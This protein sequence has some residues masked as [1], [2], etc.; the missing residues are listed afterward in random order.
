[1][2]YMK[3]LFTVLVLFSCG[4]MLRLLDM[5]G[6]LLFLQGSFTG[7]CQRPDSRFEV[8]CFHTIVLI[9][10]VMRIEQVR[11]LH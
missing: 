8:L 3:S 4:N 10:L 9:S 5:S 1:M 2:N 7:S 6:F 11:I